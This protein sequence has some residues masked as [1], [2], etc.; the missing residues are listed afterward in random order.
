MS[1]EE[2]REKCG[3]V[4]MEFVYRQVLELFM[5]D[6]FRKQYYIC[7]PSPMMAEVYDALDKH[8]V[9]PKD[10]HMEYFVLPEKEEVEEQE[11]S[12]LPTKPPLEDQQ[13]KVRLYEEDHEIEVKAD[14]TLLAATIRHSLNPPYACRAG[15]CVSCK[16]KVKQ[17]TAYMEPIVGLS[18]EEIEE[19]YILTCQAYPTSGDLEIEFD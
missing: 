2:G 7:G 17:G 6:E 5:Q 19:G 10:I 11:E 4:D 16:A 18:D 15:L 9:H 8:A 1:K 12:L 14:E 13:V 3:R